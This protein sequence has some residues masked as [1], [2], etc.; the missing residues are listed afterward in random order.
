MK[1]FYRVPD[2][3]SQM[4]EL[5]GI[6]QSIRTKDCRRYECSNP[7]LDLQKLK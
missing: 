5:D 7:D 1:I 3:I 6:F 2:Q 4:Y